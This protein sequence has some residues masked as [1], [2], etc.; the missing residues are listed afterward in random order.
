MLGIFWSGE[1]HVKKENVSNKE[2]KIKELEKWLGIYK[3][4]LETSQKETDICR[5]K[6]DRFQKETDYMKNMIYEMQVELDGIHRS[7]SWR[8]MA[9]FRKCAGVYRI[10]KDP[11]L[12]IIKLRNMKY[13][14]AIKYLIPK[15]VR[16]KIVKRYFEAYGTSFQPANTAQEDEMFQL[17]NQFEQELKDGQKLLLVFSGVKY[18]DS[19]G[20]RS[21]RLIHEARKTGIGIVF[22]YWR[23]NTVEEIEPS[24]DGLAK[25][26]MDLLDKNKVSFFET[27]F[28][29]VKNKCLLVEFPHPCAVQV[30]EIANSFGWKTIYDVIDDWEEFARFGQAQWYKKKAERR[31]ANIVD[32]NV[33]TAKVLKEKIE[34]DLILEKPFHLISNGVDTDRMKCVK[35]LDS[36]DYTKGKLQIGYFGH[37]TDAWFDWKLIIKLAGKHPEWTFHIIGY[38]EPKKIRVPENVILYGKKRPE[39][40]PKYAAFWD[41]SIIPFLNHEL[42]RAVNPIKVF[43]YLQLRLPVVATYMPEIEGYPYVD[44]TKTEEEFEHAIRSCQKLHMDEQIVQE[45]IEHN[46]WKQKCTE[47]MEYIDSLQK[48]APFSQFQ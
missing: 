42:T 33:A 45:F 12:L 23:W 4:Q 14:S 6:I 47:M 21:I 19:E 31:I 9:P 26:P 25:I 38:G 39:E 8:L 10:L 29:T 30:I 2:Q 32:A 20:Q 18:V 11:R 36:Y 48:L 40:L 13:I 43:E 34:K 5:N 1:E 3:G 7:A 35:K 37:L 16:M 24:E 41:I 15:K 46:T 27:Y 22:A 44:V 28:K 17:L